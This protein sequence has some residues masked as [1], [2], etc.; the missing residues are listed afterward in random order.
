MKKIFFLFIGSLFLNCFQT[1]RAQCNASNSPTFIPSVSI[2]SMSVNGM[3]G[4]M[5]YAFNANTLPPGG[6]INYTI[7]GPGFSGPVSNTVVTIPGV[8]TITI[9]DAYNNCATTATV[10]AAVYPAP[11]LTLSASS[12]TIC[13]SDLVTC[14]VAG[15]STYS[16][17]SGPTTAT[18]SNRPTST[19][20]YSVVGTNSLGCAT[21]GSI[22]IVVN[23]LPSLLY[24]VNNDPICQ[25]GTLSFTATGAVSYSWNS[26]AGGSVFTTPPFTTIGSYPYYYAVAGTGTNGCVSTYSSAIT[27][28]VNG[29]SG[30]LDR[31]MESTLSF[32]PNPVN[33][34]LFIENPSNTPITSIRFLSSTAQW[35]PCSVEQLSHNTYRIG[36]QTLPA[37]FYFIYVAS[38]SGTTYYSFVK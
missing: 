6:V 9:V 3:C 18:F 2:A 5:V 31:N 13:R 17:S 36:T 24:S 38:E 30:L 20:T 19:I 26:V 4:A 22:T 25:Q 10:L 16:W 33:D 15:A 37:G 35:M 27:V 7:S 1:L 32:F 8:Y 11:Q 14:S 34:F 28:T 21:T 29:C 12:S 23:P